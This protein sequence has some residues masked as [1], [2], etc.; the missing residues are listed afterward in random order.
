MGYAFIEYKHKE[1]A[2]IA[3]ESMNG[4]MLYGK[5]LNCKVIEDDEG[6]KVKTKKFKYIPYNK[7]FITQKNKEKE[8]KEIKKEVKSLLKHEEKRRQK[9]KELGIN[10]DF[11]G[12]VRQLDS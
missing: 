6:I 1:V 12:F 2:K 10:Y 11:P 4:Y 8:A 9:I 7:I 5:K 3:A